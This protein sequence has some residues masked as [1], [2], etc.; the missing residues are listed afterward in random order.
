MTVWARAL[1]C[2]WR[3][4]HH[5]IAEKRLR[6]SVTAVLTGDRR[7]LC[8]PVHTHSCFFITKDCTDVPLAHA[9]THTSGLYICSFVQARSLSPSAAQ[10]REQDSQTS[11]NPHGLLCSHPA[12]QLQVWKLHLPGEQGGGFAGWE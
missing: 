7:L 1:C 8:F 4:C 10:G 9:S 6:G 2:T 11:T 12:P 3:L 5:P